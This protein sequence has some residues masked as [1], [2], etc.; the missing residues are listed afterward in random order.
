MEWLFRAHIE[1][2]TELGLIPGFETRNLPYLTKQF[3][4]WQLDTSRMVIEAP[5]NAA[6]FQM[7]PSKVDCEEAL[8]FVQN[9]EVIGFS[10]LAGGYLKL[11]EAFD[12]ISTLK[13]LSGVAIGVSSE[14]Q[15]VS[16]F[17][18]AKRVFT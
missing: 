9:A 2:M 4:K 15:A 11:P 1:L 13:C 17:S 3:K 16:T 7:C 8:E 5:F 6:G 18:L 14:K 10:I 12:Y